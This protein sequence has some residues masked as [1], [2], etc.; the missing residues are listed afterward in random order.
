MISDLIEFPVGP[1]FLC[2]FQCLIFSPADTQSIG[3]KVL[4]NKP[5]EPWCPN[6]YTRISGA[7]VVWSS[8][9][10]LMSGFDTQITWR[11]TA[12]GVWGRGCILLKTFV[13]IMFQFCFLE[14][15]DHWLW[16]KFLYILITFCTVCTRVY[17]SVTLNSNSK[18]NRHVPRFLV[19]L[20]LTSKPVIHEKVSYVGKQSSTQ[21]KKEKR[22][23]IT[24][25]KV[26]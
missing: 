25:S 24:T 1:L 13:G 23:A 11:C 12:L 10:V 22:K 14:S 19:L 20:H 8:Y 3:R 16:E 17:C 26:L 21:S 7:H 15:Q 6:P 2:R 4:G 18:K 5:Y 9:V